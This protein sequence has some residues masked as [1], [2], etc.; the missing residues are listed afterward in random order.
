MSTNKRLSWHQPLVPQS[1]AKTAIYFRVE[2]AKAPPDSD[3]TRGSC[4]TTKHQHHL[5]KRLETRNPPRA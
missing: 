2:T 1:A 3:Y 4:G 5:S